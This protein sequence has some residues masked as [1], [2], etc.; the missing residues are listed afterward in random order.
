MS[1]P[2]CRPIEEKTKWHY[3]GP[4]VDVFDC[5]SCKIP[6][7][8]WHEHKKNITNLDKMHGRDICIQLFG[9]NISWRGPRKILDHYHEHIIMEVKKNENRLDS[10]F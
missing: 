2:L 1:C 9:K 6:M 5:I 3:H 4:Y 7:W 8:V 10:G